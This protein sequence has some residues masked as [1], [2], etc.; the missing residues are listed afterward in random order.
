MDAKERF[1]GV[2]GFEEI[3]ELQAQLPSQQDLP[4]CPWHEGVLCPGECQYVLPADACLHEADVLHR[5]TAPVMWQTINGVDMPVHPYG[6][7]EDLL[8]EAAAAIRGLRARLR[9]GDEERR[10]AGT[11][12]HA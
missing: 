4:A 11:D 10:E 1:C 2:C 9:P 8:Q 5:I 3:R 7:M 6:P 12:A